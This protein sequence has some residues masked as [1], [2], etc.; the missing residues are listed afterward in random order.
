VGVKV[1]EVAEMDVDEVA[2]V[3]EDAPAEVGTA[4]VVEMDVDDVVEVD[5]LDDDELVLEVVKD[6]DELPADDVGGVL[7]ALPFELEVGV[8][9][10]LGLGMGKKPLIMP[11]CLPRNS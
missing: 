9:A 11:S 4:E 5:V 10:G 3:D 6:V 1:D 7:N 2:E 8:A